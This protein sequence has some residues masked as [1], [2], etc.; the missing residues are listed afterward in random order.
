VTKVIQSRSTK[1]SAGKAQV[2]ANSPHTPHTK[3]SFSP[4]V[5]ETL[6]IEQYAWFLERAENYAG[7]FK[8]ASDEFWEDVNSLRAVAQAEVAKP[9]DKLR[10]GRTVLEKVPLSPVPPSDVYVSAFVDAVRDRN[11]PERREARAR[12]LGNSLGADGEASAR[13]SRDICSSE[14]AK[15]KLRKKTMAKQ[16]IAKISDLHA[17]WLSR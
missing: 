11:F 14:R 8:Y 15:K 9:R 17:V 12:F 1:F 3:G 16:A 5:S 2:S 4:Q 13:R 7:T 10:L 6:K